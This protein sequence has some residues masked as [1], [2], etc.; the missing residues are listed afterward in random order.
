MNLTKSKSY[1][2][3]RIQSKIDKRLKY[4]KYIVD[5]TTDIYVVAIEICSLITKN[6]DSIEFDNFLNY[7]VKF[8]RDE[9][10]MMLK[11]PS[12]FLD[13]SCFAGNYAFKKNCVFCDKYMRCLK[14]YRYKYIANEIYKYMRTKR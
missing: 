12:D 1:N 11:N 5:N 7:V 6:Y 13:M 10:K 3:K 8:L 14:L 2:A 9:T 4:I